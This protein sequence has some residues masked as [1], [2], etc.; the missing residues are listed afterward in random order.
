MIEILNYTKKPLQ[1]I[2]TNASYCYNTKLKDEEHATR[3]AK[4]CINSGHGRNLEFADVT[5]KITCSARVAREVFTHIGGTPTRVQ[6][7]TRYITYND[8]NYITPN[9]LSEEQEKEYH[10]CMKSIRDSYRT[11]K[12]MNL[13][14]DITGY[15]LPLAMETTFI[16]KGNVRTLENMFNQRL[17]YRALEEYRL[18]MKEL[19][20]K[21]SMLDDEWKWIS[22][23]LFVPKC[24][25]MGFC[26]EDK[27]DC[28][29]YKEKQ[30]K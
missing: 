17:C 14:N 1:V 6:A 16:W 9:G 19:K 20:K 24:T 5:L 25:K 13:E 10:L 7:S 11:L 8:F 18:L 22:D 28:K 26:I 2:G 4:H 27:K 12:E 3:I 21:L 23:N 15:I 29:L 30:F